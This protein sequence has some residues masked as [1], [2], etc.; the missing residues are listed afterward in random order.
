MKAKQFISLMSVNADSAG[1][2]PLPLPPI[3]G[4]DRARGQHRAA[5][6]G[7]QRRKG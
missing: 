1:F 4:A 7:N 2:Q 3:V 6:C 5:G